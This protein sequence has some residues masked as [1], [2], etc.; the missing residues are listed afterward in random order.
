MDQQLSLAVI[1]GRG[2]PGGAHLDIA[3][4]KFLGLFIRLAEPHGLTGPIL[5]DATVKQEDGYR[6]IYTLPFSETDVLV[7]DTY[8][9]DDPDLENAYRG[10][11]NN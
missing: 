4:Q 10:K 5:M 3:F 11:W 7:E 1:D 8:Y 6:F 2:E 9:A